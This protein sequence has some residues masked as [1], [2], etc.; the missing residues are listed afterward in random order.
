MISGSSLLTSAFGVAER[1][2]I[3]GAADFTMV[4]S[5]A[6]AGLTSGVVVEVSSYHSLSHWSGVAA[7]T[8]VA[9]ALYPAVTRVRT[10]EPV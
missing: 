2:A 1:A 9:A 8:L 4:T 7:L 5:G 6:A 3:Q 10:P